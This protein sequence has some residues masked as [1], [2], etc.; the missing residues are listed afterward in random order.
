VAAQRL[1]H[2]TAEVL[3]GQALSVIG[4]VTDAEA[5]GSDALSKLAE[6]KVLRQ[7]NVVL[8]I[9]GVFVL[10]RFVI[11]NTDDTDIQMNLEK[12]TRTCVRA[13]TREVLENNRIIC[14]CIG[15][16]I[17]QRAHLLSRTAHDYIATDVTGSLC[18][19]AQFPEGTT[20][21]HAAQL[22]RDISADHL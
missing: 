3:Q 7:L 15:H 17:A 13:G 12:F 18:L 2:L 20:Y 19:E 8:F 5:L 6:L 9:H 1:Q 22:L 21:H 14:I 10:V 4:F 11:F 16:L